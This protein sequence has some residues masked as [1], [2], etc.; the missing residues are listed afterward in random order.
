MIREEHERNNEAE[1]SIQDQVEMEHMPQLEEV[2]DNVRLDGLSSEM[3]V[4]DFQ[5]LGLH[6]P[7]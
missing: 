1:K 7:L 6:P 5:R 2:Y 3:Q 4:L